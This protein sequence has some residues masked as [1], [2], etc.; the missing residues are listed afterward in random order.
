M[1]SSCNL[2]LSKANR[3][4]LKEKKKSPFTIIKYYHIE[5]NTILI[6]FFLQLRNVLVGKSQFQ[7]QMSGVW[8]ASNTASVTYICDTHVISS[9]LPSYPVF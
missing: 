2:R 7:G 6:I 9:K 3:S 5:F 1:N 8:S 4:F